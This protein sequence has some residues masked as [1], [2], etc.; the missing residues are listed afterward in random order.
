M[1]EREQDTAFPGLYD[2]A[3]ID[4]PV[5]ERV[6][7]KSIPI[8]IIAFLISVA[9]ARG[10]SLISSH[11]RM[12]DAVHQATALSAAMALKALEDESSLFAP[13]AAPAA[14][15]A[16]KDLLTLTFADPDTDLMI[17]DTDGQVLA[18]TGASDSLAGRTLASV[19]PGLISAHR[20][21]SG[22]VSETRIDGAPY[23]VSMHLAGDEGGMVVALHAMNRMNALWRAEVNLNVTLFAA[24]ALLLLVVTYAYYGQLNRADG[25][26]G[27]MGEE[28]RLRDAMLANG[29]AGLWSFDARTKSVALDGSASAV[30]GF[31]SAG[32]ALSYRALLGLVHPA[33]RAGLGRSLRPSDDGVIET[34]LRLKAADGRHTLVHVRAHAAFRGGKLFISGAAIRAAGRHAHALDA[35][36][37]RA[38]RLQA[39]I[40]ALPQALALWHRDGRL[41]AANRAFRQAYALDGGVSNIRR[42]DIEGE[43]EAASV[44]V[45]RTQAGAD[46]LSEV[47][48]PN[49]AWLQL[50]ESETDGGERIT[51][52]TDITRFKDEQNRLQA[53]QERLRQK[54]NELAASRRR[55]EQKCA[56]LSLRL[57]QSAP[58]HSTI[59][60]PNTSAEIRTSLTTVLG[61]SELLL[62]ESSANPACSQ[63]LC[64]YARSVHE[65]GMALNLLV[66]RMEN[67]PVRMSN[68]EPGSIIRRTVA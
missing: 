25:V 59:D 9:L 47:L 28:R 5:V 60:A 12:E 68:V 14:K 48:S 57:E 30:L 42:E 53:E 67:G 33:D 1:A 61:Y 4:R 10:F 64:D 24:M 54:I 7:K 35:A 39:A 50:C 21:A 8:L 15:A 23:L 55:L 46:Q 11:A 40:D 62:A 38:G 17:I 32:R 43:R 36:T 66:E 63:K 49:G 18:A 45:R 29:D 16:L 19:F 20:T 51:V 3:G 37:K 41:D 56:S 52:G 2:L 26:T 6:L 58:A 34:S 27:R 13:T 65:G 44:V 22:A 31:G